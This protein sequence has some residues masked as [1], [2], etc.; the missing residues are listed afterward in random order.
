[1]SPLVAYHATRMACRASIQE[2]GLLPNRAKRGLPHGVYVFRADNSFSH[3]GYNSR[4]EW[5]RAPRQ[6][7]WEV[8]YIGPLTFD[9]YVLNGLVLLGKV[10]H[11]TLVTGNARG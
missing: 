11:V 7:L 4:S 3:V 9:P 2:N 1:M 10:D 8:A 6:D 5:T